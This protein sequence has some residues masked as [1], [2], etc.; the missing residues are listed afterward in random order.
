[1]ALRSEDLKGQ[2]EALT[3]DVDG[4]GGEEAGMTD[5]TDAKKQMAKSQKTMK[6]SALPVIMISVLLVTFGALAAVAIYVVG[7][8]FGDL[9]DAAPAKLVNG[10]L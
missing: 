10:S 6:D 4:S 5:S 3:E 9:E 1:M 8:A 2:R 7:R